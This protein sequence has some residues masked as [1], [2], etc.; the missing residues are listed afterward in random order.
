MSAVASAERPDSLLVISE[1]YELENHTALDSAQE[2]KPSPSS[3][4]LS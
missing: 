3:I 4:P 2:P 1:V